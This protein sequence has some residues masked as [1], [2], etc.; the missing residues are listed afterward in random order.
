MHVIYITHTYTHIYIYTHNLFI[1]AAHMAAMNCVASRSLLRVVAIIHASRCIPWAGAEYIWLCDDERVVRRAFG[2]VMQRKIGVVSGGDIEPVD[3][4]PQV[5]LPELL[6]D[7]LLVLGE[8]RS[9]EEA[10]AKRGEEQA[11]T[12]SATRHTTSSR[13]T[14]A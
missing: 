3:G 7:G 2:Q 13:V 6:R 8:E 10:E 9:D 1:A 11:S 14:S 4:G 5:H 12:R